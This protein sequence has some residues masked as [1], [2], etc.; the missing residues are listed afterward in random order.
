MPSMLPGLL[1]FGVFQPVLLTYFKEL[2]SLMGN[3][4]E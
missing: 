3:G 2:V 4:L 1:A